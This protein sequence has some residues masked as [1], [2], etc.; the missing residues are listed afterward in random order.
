MVHTTSIKNLYNSKLSWL[1][2]I[3]IFGI[4]FLHA[5]REY[6]TYTPQNLESDFEDLAKN[7]EKYI[8]V[9]LDDTLYSDASGFYKLLPCY[10]KVNTKSINYLIQWNGLANKWQLMNTGVLDSFQILHR[11]LHADD[12]KKIS[13]EYGESISNDPLQNHKFNLMALKEK[14]T[15]LQTDLD[16]TK[17][18]LNSINEKYETLKETLT[19][20]IPLEE[21]EQIIKDVL[22]NVNKKPNESNLENE[23]NQILNSAQT[24]DNPP[25]EYNENLNPDRKNTPKLKKNIKDDLDQFKKADV[26]NEQYEISKTVKYHEMF[27]QQYKEKFNKLKINSKQNKAGFNTSRNRNLTPSRK[28]FKVKDESQSEN[29]EILKSS[30]YYELWFQQYKNK[31]LQLKNDEKQLKDKNKCSTMSSHTSVENKIEEI[32]EILTK[33][34]KLLLK[35]QNEK[36]IESFLHENQINTHKETSK[37]T[38]IK[39]EKIRKLNKEI[40]EQ[41]LNLSTEKY[42]LLAIIENKELIKK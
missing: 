19:Q 7:P 8:T 1:T 38:K 32:S 26:E 5:T 27:L 14:N 41:N 28:E 42:K 2:L 9:D 4:F 12:F 3:Y 10:R 16:K 33:N 40:Q 20:M 24:F 39:L 36:K 6:T 37:Q 13:F 31:F 30:K 17:E 29:N 35:F 25:N 21:V 18:E 15:K 23:Q 34:D 22:Q 11:Q